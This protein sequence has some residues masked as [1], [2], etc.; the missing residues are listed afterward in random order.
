MSVSAAVLAA[1]AAGLVSAPHCAAMCGPLAL[2][3]C[4]AP[5]RAASWR[6][7]ARYGLGRLTSYV[8]IGAVAGAA[9]SG[10]VR[11]LRD[12]GLQR[13]VSLAVAAGLALAAWRVLRLRP[14]AALVTLRR[15]RSATRVPAVVLGLLTGL[16]PCGALAS[17]LLI[18]AGAGAWWGGAASMAVFALASA[19]GRLAGVLPATGLRARLGAAATPTRR[20]V[21]A[22]IL[23]AAACWVGARPWVMPERRCHCHGA[24]AAAADG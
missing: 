20:R 9:G 10:L 18:A 3:A 24:G 13:W 22:L 23:L 4:D 17:G 21:G 11:V 14:P 12:E 1:A 19:P 7:G 16:L 2:A 8:V 5:D 15:A 6:A